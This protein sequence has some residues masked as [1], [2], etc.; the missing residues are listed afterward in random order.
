ME[1]KFPPLLETENSTVSP[2]AGLSD[3]DYCKF[4]NCWIMRARSPSPVWQVWLPLPVNLTGVDSV[5]FW[6]E[7]NLYFLVSIPAWQIIWLTQSAKDRKCKFFHQNMQRITFLILKTSKSKDQGLFR[8]K[9]LPY[10]KPPENDVF[11]AAT[12]GPKQNVFLQRN[13]SSFLQTTNYQLG[14]ER[15]KRTAGFKEQ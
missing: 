2:L 13:C 8:G 5:W 14:E 7:N 3:S 15:S 6:I 10:L 11:F 12:V 9:I 4:T 1:G